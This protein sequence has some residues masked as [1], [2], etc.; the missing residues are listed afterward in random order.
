MVLSFF[1]W[2]NFDG[3]SKNHSFKDAYKYIYSCLLVYTIITM[4]LGIALNNNHI[5]SWINI[6]PRK[7]LFDYYWYILH[8]FILQCLHVLF[9][10]FVHCFIKIITLYTRVFRN[11]VNIFEYAHVVFIL[12]FSCGYLHGKQGLYFFYNICINCIVFTKWFLLYMYVY[13]FFNR[14]INHPKIENRFLHAPT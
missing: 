12:M 5:L 13:I 8:K 9:L 11:K 14:Q 3:F 6:N 4:L 10:F 1:E 7:S 2:I